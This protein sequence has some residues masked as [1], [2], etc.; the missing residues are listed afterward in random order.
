MILPLQTKALVIR[1]IVCGQFTM[2]W[3][4][5]KLHHKVL[6]ILK[7]EC[8]Q[9][10]KHYLSQPTIPLSDDIIKYWYVNSNMYP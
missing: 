8:Q 3:L 9:N 7:S 5:K 10:L 4:Q 1:L 2:S 6:N